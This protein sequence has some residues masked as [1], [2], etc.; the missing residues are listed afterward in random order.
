MT[1]EMCLVGQWTPL[2]STLQQRYD[3]LPSPQCT[4]VTYIYA[5]MY[6]MLPFIIYDAEIRNILC[7][8]H[9]AI[10]NLDHIYVSILVAMV[11]SLIHIM[12]YDNYI[13]IYI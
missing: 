2:S 3:T 4:D 7:H 1:S 5:F 11:T 6:K 12:I 8:L 9:E 13:Y 10:S